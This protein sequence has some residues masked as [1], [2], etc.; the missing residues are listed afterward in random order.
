MLSI[1]HPFLSPSILHRGCDRLEPIP[2]TTGWRHQDKSPVYHRADKQA[3][4]HSLL[5]A[6]NRHPLTLTG[7]PL[8]CGRKLKQLR[9]VCLLCASSVPCGYFFAD[10]PQ[11][12]QT[13]KQTA[14]DGHVGSMPADHCVTVAVFISR[15]H[16]LPLCLNDGEGKKH[17]VVVDDD[18][19]SKVK[20][21]SWQ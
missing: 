18:H 16:V 5:W 6:I 3:H 10:S 15:E 4:S 12:N 13:W 17:V 11:Q 1:I 8:D 20:I 21:E 19:K 7:M 2:A 14:A 9:S